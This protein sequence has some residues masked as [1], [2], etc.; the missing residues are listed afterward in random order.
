[1][2]YACEADD[3]ALVAL[4][5]NLGIDVNIKDSNYRTAAAYAVENNFYEIIEALKNAGEESTN[6]D[7]KLEI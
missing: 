4:L 7:E 6:H 3:I 2:H 5:I 1:M